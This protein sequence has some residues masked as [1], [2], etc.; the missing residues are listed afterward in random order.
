[1]RW[2]EGS[3]ENNAAGRTLESGD[4]TALT[5]LFAILSCTTAQRDGVTAVH[6]GFFSDTLAAIMYTALTW[7]C[8]VQP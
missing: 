4:R 1:M 2:L 6:P 7:N 8:R 3:V 5:K